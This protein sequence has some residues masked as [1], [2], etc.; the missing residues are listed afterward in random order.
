M[1]DGL[2]LQPGTA[3]F[4]H[5]VTEVAKLAFA[6]REAWYGDVDDVPLATLLSAAYAAERRGLITATA[7]TD[8]RP[9]SPDGR[10]P[11]SPGSMPP[12]APR[13]APAATRPSPVPASPG[14]TPAT[15]MWSTAGAR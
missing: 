1:L 5:Q 12:R 7:S 9:G 11:V 8:L 4:V 15:S 6:D 2:G 14:A 3:D 10:T 13:S